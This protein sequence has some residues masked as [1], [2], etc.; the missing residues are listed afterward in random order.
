MMSVLVKAVY[1]AAAEVKRIQDGSCFDK[2]QD[3]P[4]PEAE[5]KLQASEGANGIH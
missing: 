2:H 1:S 4:L 5:V 3:S